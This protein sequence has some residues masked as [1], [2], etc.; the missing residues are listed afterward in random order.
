MGMNA[1]LNLP[2]DVE[3][4]KAIILAQQEQNTRLEALIAAL[5]QAMFGRK[6]EKI[7]PGQFELALED[8]EAGIARVEAEG[9]A[10]ELIP[11]KAASKP[12]KTNRGSLPRHLP[13]I[14]VVIEPEDVTCA[15][16]AD[17]HVIGEDVSERLDVIPAQFRVIVTRRPKYACR[18]CTNGVVQAPA[19]ARLIPG[20]LP[21]EATVAHVLVS[22]YADHLPL[23]RQAQI[24]S[25]QGI[26]LDRSTLAAWVGRAA[27][28]LRPVFDALM[29]DLKRSSKLF[30]DET[31]APVLDPGK[32]KTKTG[33]FW[34]LAR[35]DRPWGGDDPPGVAF[36]YA[37]GRSGQYA[38]DILKGFSGILQVDG[39]AGY[40]RLLNRTDQGIV[41]AYCWAHARRKLHDIAHNATAPIAAEGLRQI[42]ALYRVEKE[43]QGLNPQARVDARQTRSAPLITSFEAWLN[44]NRARVS[45]KTPLGEALKYIAKY[46]EGLCLFL[47]DGR[48]ELDSNTVERTIRPIALNRKNALFAGHDAGA[49][50]WG[51]I[52]SFIETCKLNSVAPLAWLTDTLTAIINGHKQHR[53]DE[54]LP[55]NYP[56]NV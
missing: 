5:R 36:T 14:E 50:N 24:Y 22:K 41:L 13:R 28:E 19:P 43:I 49:E 17:C 34:A 29:S 26:D 54:L 38:E 33:Y 52:A 7:D 32:R 37:P 35:D 56:V 8:I 16:G 39:Y 21:T 3:A 45:S 23:Y 20:G 4:L 48:I 6:S 42:A 15:C 1:P 40:N 27:F 11:A 12:R 25:R 10:N 9:E 31:R 46:W 30:M 18:S 47:T 2:D 44:A 55:W 51:V 53:I